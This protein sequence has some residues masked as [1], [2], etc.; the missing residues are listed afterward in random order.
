[1]S[2][3][4]TIMERMQDRI[5]GREFHVQYTCTT[6]QLFGWIRKLIKKIKE[7]VNE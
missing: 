1:M 5:V 6:D 7:I 4:R 2:D 3:D